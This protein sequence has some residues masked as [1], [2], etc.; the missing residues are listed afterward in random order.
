MEGCA[1]QARGSIRH[2]QTESSSVGIGQ[3][4][5]V[6]DEDVAAGIVG[7]NRIATP[8][9]ITVGEQG[10]GI[11]IGPT[12]SSVCRDPGIPVPGFQNIASITGNTW[13]IYLR[14]GMNSEVMESSVNRCLAVNLS[15]ERLYLRRSNRSSI[16][17]SGR[18]EW[19]GR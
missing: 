19:H 2:S 3:V 10:F 8:P 13:F 4:Q 15:R 11:V 17:D 16:A 7:R 1:R 6:P 12:G 14:R 5:Q 9:A 18:D